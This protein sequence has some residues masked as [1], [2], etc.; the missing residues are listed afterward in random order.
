MHVV[1]FEAVTEQLKPYL[2]DY[3]QEH[4]INTDAKFS[5][6][7]PD[8]ADTSPSANLVGIE[9]G[10]PRFFCHGCGRSG[11]IFDAVQLMEEKPT[12][13]GEWVQD[14]LKY[15]AEKY[16]VSVECGDISDEQ[17]Y[18]IDTYRAYR[19]AA[20]IIKDT[21]I[22]ESNK[23]YWTE[24]EHRGWEQEQLQSQGVGTVLSYEYFRETLKKQGFAASFLDEIDLSR[25]DLFNP[26][27]LIFTWKDE[28]G[29]PIGFASRNLRF[30]EQQENAKK[31]NKKSTV[32]KYTNQR[33][34]G[35]KCNIFQKGRRFYG[36][37]QAL[38]AGTAVYVFEGY[39]DVITARHHG[40]SNSVAIGGTSLHDD[41][42]HL[43]KT[44]G[45]Y[46]IILCLDG[47]KPGQDK[48]ADILETKFAG[49]R[50]MRV[51]VVILPE[52]DDPDSFIRDNGAGAFKT[53]AHWS[54]FEWRLNKYEDE[55][56]EEDICRQMIPFIVNESS[57]VTREQQCKALSKRTGVS[58]KSINAELNI[59]LDAKAHKRSQARQALIDK[60]MY[61]L[62]SDPENAEVILQKT[63]S[64]LL[65]L[66]KQHDLDTLSNENFVRFLDE[67]KNTQENTV[68]G[69]VGFRLGKQL[70]EL[71]DALRGEWADGVFMCIGGKPNVGKS[72][73]L[74]KLACSIAENNDDVVVLYH[75]ID[76]T[77]QQ[78]MPRFVTVLE[79]STKL[80]MNM[81]R[82]PKYWTE[83]AKL[84][85]VPEKRAIGY[86]KLRK[87]ALDGRIVIKDI[88]HGNSLP[89]AENLIAYFQEKYPERRVVYILDN[90]HKLKDYEGKDERVRFKAISSAIDEIALRRKCCIISSV[91]YTKLAP[92][93]KPTNNN[94]A[95][96]GQIEYDTKAIIHLYSEV[97]DK[98]ESFSICHENIDWQGNKR[99]EPR[100]EFIIGKNK[101]TEIKK[102]FFMDFYPAASDFR[103][104]DQTVVI[105]DKKKMQ[106]MI[107]AGSKHDFD[108]FDAMMEDK[109]V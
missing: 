67:E 12:L 63:Q 103:A 78:L 36:L 70:K 33:T 90:F 13:G 94:I 64:T 11:D 52:A 45:V 54:A 97:A 100:V 17:I 75:T 76:D 18:E 109:D 23:S 3:L 26:D 49:H 39:A 46:D 6:L 92:G 7:F 29:R 30:E 96:T 28:K 106:E 15:L 27:N 50:D 2:A 74:A 85:Y 56:D 80:S 22:P 35:L 95:E 93:I 62:R 71:E 60:A 32:P 69:D 43:L 58:F 41:H 53:L 68:I 9:T 14:T 48:L 79:G 42:V 55:A 47:D 88:E 16:G 24:L 20:N 84:G 107:K 40:L 98:P 82:Q 104:V 101:I 19:A 66:A 108:Q 65:N 38:K 81:T 10:E 77:A 91:E 57:P 34:T 1:D 87:L 8:H 37:D 83:V 72:A 44:L 51:R 25:K 102:S 89:F 5:C 59:T 21:P 105:Q 61:E 99:L 31:N 73:F 86:E 4:G